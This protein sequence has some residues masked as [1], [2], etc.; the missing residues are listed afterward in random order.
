MRTIFTVAIV[1]VVLSACATTGPRVLYPPARRADVKDDYHGTMVADP[2]RW[3][4]DANSEETLEFVAAQNRLTRAYVDT[5]ERESVKER[6]TA[7]WDFPRISVIRKRGGRYFFWKND[8]LQDQPVLWVRDALDAEPR[9]ILDPNTLSDDGTVAVS[10]DFPSRDGRFLA[11]LVSESGSDWQE[12][13]VMDVE[14]GEVLPERLKRCKFTS[15]AWR[16]DN[17]G[18]FYNR[19]PDEGEVPKENENHFNR[20]LWHVLRTPQADDVLVYER[21]DDMML[22]FEPM[23]TDDGRFLMLHVFRGTSPKHRIYVRDVD[24]DGPFTKLLD[25]EDATYHVVGNAGRTLYVLTDRDAP[26]K[27]VVAID[28][29]DPS[30]DSWRTMVSE[31]D[32]EVIEWADVI[33]GRIVIQTMSHARNRLW[34]HDMAGERLRALTLPGM[35]SVAGFHG[36]QDDPEMFFGFESFLQPDSVYRYDMEADETTAVSEPPIDFDSTGFVTRQVFVTSKDGTRVPMFLTHKKGHECEGGCPTI[37]YGYGGFNI[38]LTPWFNPGWIPWIENGGV[39]AL[40][41]L[42]GGTE[43]GE[44][45]HKAGMLENKQNVFDDFIAAAKWLVENGIASPDSLVA[46]GGSNGGLL[47]AAVEVQR[48]GLFDAVVSRVPVIDMLRFQRFSVGSL[49]TPEY[50]NAEEDPEHF[51]FLY[52]YSPLHNVKPG[53]VYPPTLITTA[54]TDDRVV[55]MHGKKFAAALQHADSGTNSILL[56]IETRAGHGGGKPTS[57]RIDEYAD[58]YGFLIRALGLRL[59]D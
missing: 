25:E 42:R 1:S 50:G 40:V 2:Y 38:S 32:D 45:W 15:V 52:T 46:T 23:I 47:V 20:V 41:N 56:R 9:V 39:Y 55:P 31:P 59:D 51:R 48:P 33:G 11:Y 12:M 43:Y 3:L 24:S 49:W 58:I 7:I 18:F 4:E 28:M 34:I 5:P 35:G 44:E 29:D 10:G 6:L 17:S 54:D 14:T 19:Y 13:R 26:R 27:R 22:G 16:H 30:P 21:P 53:T 36:D 8:G 37:L 57:K